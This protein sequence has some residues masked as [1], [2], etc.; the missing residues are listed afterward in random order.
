MY[1]Y[2]AVN[3]VQQLREPVWEQIHKCT[4]T[5]TNKYRNTLQCAVRELVW[6]FA[7]WTEE[8]LCRPVTQS[9]SIIYKVVQAYPKYS[10]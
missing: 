10:K 1:K 6:E 2:T 9:H 5:Q 4:N 3:N 7:T 8:S